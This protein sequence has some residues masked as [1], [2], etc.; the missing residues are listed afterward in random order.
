[1]VLTIGLEV[2]LLKIDLQLFCQPCVSH[3]FVHIYIR[4]TKNI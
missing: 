4:M 1:M 3:C 2:K